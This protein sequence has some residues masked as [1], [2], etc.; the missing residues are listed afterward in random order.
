MAEI[1]WD[2]TGDRYYELGVDHVV[3]YVSDPSTDSGYGTGVAWNGVTSISESPEG[4][5]VTDLWADNIKYASLRATE[6]FKGPI[7]A[8]TYPA[9]FMECD[10]S[11]A[12]ANGIYIGQQSRK[13]FGLV[14]RTKEGNDV[15]DEAGYV[16]HI[17]YGCTVNP[18]DRDYETINDS[19][20]AITFS[21]EFDTVPVDVE[22]HKPT[23]CV[24]IKSRLVNP[25]KLTT[26]QNSLFGT[27]NTDPVLLTPDDILDII[28]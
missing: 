19:P 26:I 5:D 24:T 10:G 9:E 7:E 25:A 14:Y 2:Q 17:V 16:L 18:S 21:W 22:D 11:A 13:S 28:G 27:A 20:D 1:K 4:A 8:Y 6:D 3:L 15:T 23:A 12:L